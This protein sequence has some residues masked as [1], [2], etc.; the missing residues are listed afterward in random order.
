MKKYFIIAVAA[1]VALAACTKNEAD[2]TAY[3]NSRQIN[4]SAVAGKATKAPI[5]DNFFNH[6]NGNFGVYACYLDETKTWDANYS[7]SKIYMG[8]NAG[9]GVEVAFDN[10][11][12]IWAPTTTYYWPLEGGLTFFAYWPY[13][14]DPDYTE[15]GN[16]LSFGSFSVNETVASQVDV[17]VSSFAKNQTSSDTQAYTDGVVNSS[18]NGVQIIFNHML[19]QV[20]FTAQAASDVYSRGMSFKINDIKVGARKTSSSW[21]VV[22]GAAPSWTDP[23]VLTAFDILDADF[24]TSGYLT[25]SQSAQIGAA[26][27]MIPNSDFNGEDDTDDAKAASDNDDEYVTVTYTLYRVSDNLDMG[28]K[29]VKFWLN[30]NQSAVNNWDAGK[31]YTYQLTIGLDKIYFAPEVSSWVDETQSVTVPGNGVQI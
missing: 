24:P 7:A 3:E 2:K 23:T 4:F 27:L 15:G 11:L 10:T 21:T 28:T 1:V 8:T 16:Q 26:L 30:D 19:A 9:A 5:T 18:V 17:L 14:L 6:G 22:P 13:N 25:D 12:N 20:V 29:T 31:K